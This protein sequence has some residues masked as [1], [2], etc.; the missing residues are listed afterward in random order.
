MFS[1]MEDETATYNRQREA[2]YNQHKNIVE[3]SHRKHFILLLKCD[4][5]VSLVLVVLIIVCC[6]RFVVVVFILLRY[7]FMLARKM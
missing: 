6:C 1:V 2:K 3:K 5:S 4:C 7:F